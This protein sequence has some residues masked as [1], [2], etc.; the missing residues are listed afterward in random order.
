MLSAL[1][2]AC[3]PVTPVSRLTTSASAELLLVPE[4]WVHVK[5][6][7]H[8]SPCSVSNC[9]DVRYQDVLL[10]AQG[11]Q[12]L[13][14]CSNS[15]CSSTWEQVVAE[16]LPTSVAWQCHRAPHMKSQQWLLWCVHA[17]IR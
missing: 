2:R 10:Q 8:S 9:V 11:R 3:R 16:L 13:N 14:Q 7:L 17:Q 6:S 15:L 1:E 4:T 12:A 5:A